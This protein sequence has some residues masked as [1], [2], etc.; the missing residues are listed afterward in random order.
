MDIEQ[1]KDDVRTGRIAPDRLV[2]LVVTMQRELQ[3]AHQEL[4]AAKRQI[5]DFKRQ[6]GGVPGQKVSQPFS[7]RAEEQRQEA[8]GKKRRKRKRSRG[9]RTTTAE[10]VA[11][12]VRTEKVYPGGVP[13]ED[14]WLSHTRPVWRLENGQAVLV[15]YEIYRGPGN[16][17]GKIAGVF[18][19]SEF[20]AEITLA[21]AYQVYIVGL[22]FD[23]VCLLMNFFQHL[24]LRKSQ[25]NALLNQLARQW[26]EEFDLLCMLLA[27]SLV[28][29]T[30]ET[31]WSIR[32]VWAFLSEKVRVLFFGVHKDAETLRQ[33]LDPA[34]FAGIVISDDAAVYANFTQSQKCWAHFLRKA[35]KL[36]LMEPANAEYRQFTDRLL[37]IYHEACRVQR[38]R[39]LSAEGRK[40]KVAAMEDE[41]L[42]LC[43]PMWMAE[44][45]PGEGPQDDYRRLCNEL[46]QVMLAEQL[47]TFVTAEPVEKP[48]GETLVVA[49]TNNEAERTLRSPAQARDTCRTNKTVAGARRQTVIVSVLESL[50]QHLSTFT[51]SSVIEEIRR[52]AE[53][54]RSC[55]ARWVEKLGLTGHGFPDEGRLSLLDR[56]IP[57]PDG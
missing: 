22:S 36:T 30:D 42:E 40:G 9:G 35:I 27:N 5:E 26:Q 11:Q 1:L 21:I 3:A 17:Y 8:R 54:G 13:Q 46:M 49:G 50:R 7:V 24:K 43:A 6:L 47:F 25:A 41:I 2:E 10:K 44:L 56:V 28:V 33:I 12:A 55:F 51:L 38:D 57:V 53:T 37:E 52:W 29:H 15:A 23:K 20:G 45:P 14:C 39:R 34:T 4:D 31:G 19:R 48:N 18:G 32:S 16:Q